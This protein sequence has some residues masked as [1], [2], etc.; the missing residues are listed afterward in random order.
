M[1][2]LSFVLPNLAVAQPAK[3]DDALA[4][5][6][7]TAT[8]LCQTAPLEHTS[9]GTTLK[10]EAAAKVGGL[11]DKIAGLKVHG[12]IVASTDTS[13]TSGVIDGDL[14]AVMADTNNCRLK[15]F[16][17]LEQDLISRQSLVN[18]ESEPSITSYSLPN[19]SAFCERAKKVI[20]AAGK[21]FQSLYTEAYNPS[22]SIKPKISLPNMQFCFINTRPPLDTSSKPSIYYS[23]EI[24]SGEKSANNVQVKEK[25]YLTSVSSCLGAG[26]IKDDARPQGD[27]FGE[28]V[29]FEREFT[30]PTI[31]I[32]TSKSSINGGYDMS[33]YIEPQ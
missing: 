10:G 4:E 7:K 1:L 27:G 22:A 15:V 14:P 29:T 8:E 9:Q 24:V 13:K 3:V 18:Q 26:W 20:S 33:I 2:N 31:Q 5:I 11:T 17:L 21:K 28:R 25:Q 32:V 23:C 30:D 16:A 19:E 6:F 12:S